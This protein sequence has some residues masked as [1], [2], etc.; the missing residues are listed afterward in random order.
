MSRST[1]LHFIN[2]ACVLIECG[3]TRLLCDPWLSGTVFHNG[4]RLLVPDS[5]SC[6][7]LRPSH[8]WISHEHPDH[9]SPRDLLAIPRSSRAQVPAYYQRTVDRKVTRFL[10][11]NGFP[12]SEMG[13]EALPLA[14]GV[15][16][17]CGSVGSDSWLLVES[18]GTTILNMNDCLTLDPRVLE[19]LRDKIG[20]VDVLLTQ[21][22]YANWV[23]NPE[24]ADLH[25]RA[26]AMW[27]DQVRGQ[28]AAFTPRYVVPFASFVWFC[29]DEN[30]Y[31][32]LHMNRVRDVVQVIR[33]CGV[34][35]IVLFPG[36]VW[37]IGDVHRAEDTCVRW[38]RAY[39]DAASS[40]REHAS[41][42][43]FGKLEAS[44][45]AYVARLRRKN[46]WRALEDFSARGN[47]PA[48]N[49][50]LWD[51]ESCVRFD[52]LDGL[53]EV[54]SARGGWDVAMHSESLLNVLQH[55]W[56]RGT[57]TVNGR[58]HVNYGNVERFWRQTQIAYANNV[59]LRFPDTLSPAALLAPPN[60]LAAR[61]AR[62]SPR[63]QSPL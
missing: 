43:A 59:G 29:H 58:F 52:I 18:A 49:I 60:S 44:F 3:D 22:S 13:D 38:D 63:A 50:F 48:T 12:V 16:A 1:R 35:P 31:M 14:S 9:F 54:G 39:A 6:V 8:L 24:D 28:I 42:V 7:D 32:N 10:S 23:G 17:R 40:D 47:L 62:M 21:F 36:D 25:Q 41:P 34:E 30:A 56:G 33:D 5:P 37:A 51:Y 61:I 4:W 11:D 53:R 20:T 57:L 26:A 45:D 27:L 55:E 15:S 46:D 19:Q 2:H